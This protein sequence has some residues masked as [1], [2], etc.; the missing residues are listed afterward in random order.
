M[1]I[2]ILQKLDITFDEAK[3][4][5]LEHHEYLDGSG[6]PNKTRSLS[7]IG[8]L[9]SVA[10]AFSAMISARPYASA[11]PPFVAAQELARDRRFDQKLTS[12][13]LSAYATGALILLNS[14]DIL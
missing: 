1:T 6:Y 5:A 9:A 4:A 8:K 13:L 2:R 14:E 12:A 7:D 3:A 10:D 11:K